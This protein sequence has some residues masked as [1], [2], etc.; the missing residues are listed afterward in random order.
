MGEVVRTL[1]WANV[2]L[3]LILAV[4]PW[5]TDG[6]VTG[7]SISD[8]LVGLAV[9]ALSIPRMRITERYGLWTP[10]IK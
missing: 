8:S 6:G 10:Y 9:I 4:G 7:A 5:L 2:L 1:R 3:G